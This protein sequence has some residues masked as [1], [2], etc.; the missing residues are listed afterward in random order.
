MSAT[1]DKHGSIRLHAPCR[2][3]FVNVLDLNRSCS[4]YI[5]FI[6]TLEISLQQRNGMVRVGGRPRLQYD[7]CEWQGIT[8]LSTRGRSQP[9]RSTTCHDA[10]LNRQSWNA[11]NQRVAATRPQRVVTHRF[12]QFDYGR[13]ESHKIG[14]VPRT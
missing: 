13:F 1:R 11:R 8:T 14:I 7:Q 6:I 10:R 5:T 3:S 4:D 12:L 2:E 9:D